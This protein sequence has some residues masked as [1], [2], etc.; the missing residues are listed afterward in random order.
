M[1][2]LLLSLAILAFSPRAHAETPGDKVIKQMD[3]SMTRAK[4]Q[5]F[6][7]R[8]VTQEPGKAQRTLVMDVRIKGDEWRRIDFTDPGDIKGMK[9][10]ILSLDQTYVYLPAFRKVRRVAG[11]AKEQGFMG[12]TFSHDEM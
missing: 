8:V 12:T 3:E 4:D 1:R 9:I 7:H 2:T 11:H 10:L 6:I 5:H